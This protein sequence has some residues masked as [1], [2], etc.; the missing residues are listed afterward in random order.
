MSQYPENLLSDTT[1]ALRVLDQTQWFIILVVVGVLISLGV[2]EN[3]KMLLCK[4]AEGTN[5]EKD[6]RVLRLL[7]VYKR[8][9]VNLP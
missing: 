3:Q 1:E 9:P 5:V 8:Q 2:T 4:T 7:D 6:E